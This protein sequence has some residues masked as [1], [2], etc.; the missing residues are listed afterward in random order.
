[1]LDVGALLEF[2][3]LFWL[4][5]PVAIFAIYGS[6]LVYYGRKKKDCLQMDLEHKE[7]MKFEPLV[8]IVVPTHN[9]E[10]IISKRIENLISLDYSREKLEMIFVDDSDDST[11]NIILDYAKSNPCLSLVRFP[12]RMGYSPSMIAGCKQA[13][14][15]IVVLGDAASFL[16]S[17]AIQNFVVH[18]RDPS[19]GAVTGQDV[20][21][22]VNEEVGR[23]ES[24]YLRILNFLRIAES[25]MDS[26]FYV[27]GEA[28][29]VRSCLIRDL[30]NCSATYD[31]AVGLFVRQKGFRTIYDPQVKFYEY[32][33]LTHSDRVKQKTIRAAN[34]IRI[35]LQFKHLMFKREYGKY[36]LV[37]LPMNFAMLAIAP[38]SI[39]IGFL[40]L[41]PT[42]FFN[43][44]F[45]A[46]IWG[47]AGGILLLS[48]ALARNLLH[49]FL[50]LESSLLKALY[51]IAI[52]KKHDKI[53]KVEST[54]R[55]L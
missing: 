26:T 54:R 45:S 23:S 25:N 29:A 12:E 2:L 21:L 34:L 40:V 6:I 15:E 17:Q 55:A 33:P 14:G 31:T 27:K 47:I 46:A 5:L 22:N 52:H 19:V 35:M 44:T 11:P 30:E 43:L 16:D 8:S 28:T 39:L 37:I 48:L 3:V 10:S 53:D 18:F 50:D 42:T 9:E 24:L 20:V 36:G 41:I 7:K 38:V 51:E 4:G 32:A 49:T 1:M 13:R